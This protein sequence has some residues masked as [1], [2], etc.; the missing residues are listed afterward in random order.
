MARRYENLFKTATLVLRSSHIILACFNV[1]T[2]DIEDAP[3]LDPLAKFEIVERDGKVYIK[4]DE[5]T[6][7]ASRR[8]LNLKCSSKSQDKVVIVGGYV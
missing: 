3:A 7:K 5:A 6:I 8:K 2:G 4:G 1:N